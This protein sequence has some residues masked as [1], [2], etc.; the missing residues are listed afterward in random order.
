MTFNPKH[1]LTTVSGKPYISAIVAVLWFREENPSGAIVTEILSYEPLV[2][3][4]TIR[5]EG[6]VIATGHGTAKVEGNERAVWKGREIE[7]AETASIGR[8]LKHAGYHATALEER[9]IQQNTQQGGGQSSRPAPIDRRIDTAEKNIQRGE[10][11]ATKALVKATDNGQRYLLL[12]GLDEDAPLWTRKLLRD[13]GVECEGW[14]T[15]GD[16]HDIEPP[17]SVQWVTN[18]KGFRRVDGIKVADMVAEGA[19]L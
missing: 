8:A 1:H 4:T 13:V 14:T 9:A 3:K 6:V 12:Q 10:F 15:E 17:V 16:S 5:V 2:A 11:L 19:L 7:K 18:D